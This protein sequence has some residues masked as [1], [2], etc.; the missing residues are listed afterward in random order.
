VPLKLSFFRKT[1][2]RVLIICLEE[3]KKKCN[4]VPIYF[5]FILE[6]RTLLCSAVMVNAT[7]KLRSRA[8]KAGKRSKAAAAIAAKRSKAAI[9]AA[10]AAAAAA[11]PRPSWSEIIAAAWATDR[12]DPAWEQCGSFTNSEGE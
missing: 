2:N 6:A 1:E 9:A 4:P 10:A 3:N 12:A 8:R 11:A 5:Y 7:P